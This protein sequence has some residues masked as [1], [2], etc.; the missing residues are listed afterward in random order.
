[1][2]IEFSKKRAKI[3]D[4]TIVLLENPFIL[5][6]INFNHAQALMNSADFQWVSKETG[7]N[8]VKNPGLITAASRTG[9]AS[10][11][12]QRSARCKQIDQRCCKGR[13]QTLRIFS[14]LKIPQPRCVFTT[15]V[16][17]IPGNVGCALHCI[18]LEQSLFAYLSKVGKKLA[19]G[20]FEYTWNTHSAQ[21]RE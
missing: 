8:R 7:R 20:K 19:I 15:P 4:P 3:C 12:T 18:L 16:W 2:S 17:T 11:S 1:M 10:S 21:R 6:M 14:P 13:P 9:P 5:I